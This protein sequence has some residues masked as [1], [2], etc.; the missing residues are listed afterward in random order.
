MTNL[1]ATLSPP[2]AVD[3]TVHGVRDQY[4]AFS[5]GG[6][7]FGMDIR[8]IQEVI[9]HGGLTEVPL[10]PPFLRG[11][12]NLRGSVVP[13]IDLSVRF[14]GDRTKEDRRTCIVILDLTQ[15]DRHT[16]L[17]VMVDQVSEVLEIDGEDMDP[18]PAFG[19][20]LRP[21]FMKGIGK[22]GGRFLVLLDVNRVLAIEEMAGL[23]A[24]GNL[25]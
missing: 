20:Q 25:P 12:I 23:S 22:V 11:V 4:L 24:A 7:T 15:G 5:L 18:P 19:S 17:G 16:L 2:G 10:M 6:E 14:N 21:D 8:H 13:V 1:P 9:Q 3:S